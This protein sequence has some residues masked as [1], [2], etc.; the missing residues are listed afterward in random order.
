MHI[1]MI[2]PPDSPHSTRPAEWLLGA[3]HRVTFMS[4]R[5]PFAS[6]RDGLQF[7]RIPGGLRGRRFLV[8]LAPQIVPVADHLFI[9]LPLR[10]ICRRLKIDVVHVNC[11]TWCADACVKANLHPLVFTVWGTD[12]N[13][14][15][16]PD[17]DPV[18]RETIGR[19]LAAA[20]L[21]LVDSIDM[22][23]K[24]TVLAGQE[25]PIKRYRL[26]ID[27]T[28]FRPGYREEALV[29]R[30]KLSIPD[31][32]LVYL[33]NRALG[34]CYGHS[35]LLMAFAS[36]SQ[37]LQQEAILVINRLNAVAAHED[38]MRELARNLGVAE[39]VRW[40]DPIPMAKLPIVYAGSDIVVN[41]P[42]RD[43]F[44]VSFIEAAA[45]ERPVIT[46]DLP[47]YR[48]T[49]VE[50]HFCLVALES[51]DQLSDAMV[52]LASDGRREWITKAA[53]AR[54]IVVSEYDETR[55]A[56]DLIGQYRRLV[57]PSKAP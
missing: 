49:F 30:Q 53:E 2:A 17:A 48:D 45:C 31:D 27:T 55:C 29:W 56:E 24:C 38:E 12:I 39:R 57:A 46:C 40:M 3:G 41:V 8:R 42:I 33:H 47:A 44:P 6:E 51:I 36:V 26:G 32:A 25:L 9:H 5:N 7:I 4:E 11:I 21:I 34:P 22:F 16:A 15:F 35:T 14:H 52:S 18:Y 19:S 13:R 1:L 20:D 37:R 23:E 54:K 10:R 28:K 50:K 43:A